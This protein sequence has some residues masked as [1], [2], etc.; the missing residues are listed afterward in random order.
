MST[1][2]LTFIR[3]YYDGQQGGQHQQQGY[4][5]DRGQQGY[6]DEYYNDQYYDQGGA[7]AGYQDGY[8]IASLHFLADLLLCAILTRR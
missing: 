8:V 7:Q 5:D 6:Q 3:A 2:T 1:N 4:Y